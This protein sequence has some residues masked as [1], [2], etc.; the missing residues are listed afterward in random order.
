MGTLEIIETPHVTLSVDGDTG[1]YTYSSNTR[2]ITRTL[3]SS[4][5]PPNPNPQLDN[6][7]TS[8][9]CGWAHKHTLS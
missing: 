4:I 9:F 1:E 7:I 2:T 3:A 8:T 5:D 6:I